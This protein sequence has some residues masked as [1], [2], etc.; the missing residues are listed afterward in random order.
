M[1][2]HID[3]QP[4][5]MYRPWRLRWKDQVQLVRNTIIFCDYWSANLCDAEC[6]SLESQECCA[7]HSTFCQPSSSCSFRLLEDSKTKTRQDECRICRWFWGKYHRVW[8][9]QQRC[10]VRKGEINLLLLGSRLT[11]VFLFTSSNT[12]SPQGNDLSSNWFCWSIN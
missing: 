9:E 6:T 2:C 12:A 10:S 3:Q 1:K 5:C 4:F 7:W 8:L 11:G